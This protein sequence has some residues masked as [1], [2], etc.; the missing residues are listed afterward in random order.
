MVVSNDIDTVITA[1]A[2]SLSKEGLPGSAT[3]HS[4]FAEWSM[5]PCVW[6]LCACPPHGLEGHSQNED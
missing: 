4:A 1:P 6:L 2:D 5:V 3:I